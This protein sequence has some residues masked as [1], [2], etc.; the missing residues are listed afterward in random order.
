MMK[1][2]MLQ[3]QMIIPSLKVDTSITATLK[4]GEGVIMD[5]ETA[6]NIPETSSLQRVTLKYGNHQP[7]LCVCI[8]ETVV[9]VIHF[10]FM[11]LF[12]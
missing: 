12:V 7:S 10:R 2:A 1:D 5:V 8:T 3:V 4:K 9:S 6:I 11:H